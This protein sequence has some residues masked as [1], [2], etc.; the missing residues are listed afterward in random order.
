VVISVSEYDKIDIDE[1]TIIVEKEYPFLLKIIKTTDKCFPGK[2]RVI[3][4]VNVTSNYITYQDADDLPHPQRIEILDYFFKK[5]AN[6][7]LHLA[8]RKKHFKDIN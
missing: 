8:T 6:Y 2:N 3:G 5:V 7:I 4:S 1:I